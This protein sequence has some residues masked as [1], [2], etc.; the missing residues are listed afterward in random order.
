M[1]IFV[2][3]QSGGTSGTDALSVPRDVLVRRAL[4]MVGA[5]T[6]TDLPRPEQMTDAVMVLNLMIK[7]WSLEG[8]LWLRQFVSVSL[9]AGQNSY[10]LG[11]DGTPV[12]DRPVHIYS[13]NRMS[14]SGNEIPMVP[15]TRTD[16]MAVPNKTSVGTPVQYY[17]DPQTVNGTLY[18]WPTPPTN[19]S[20]VLKLDA[21]R[22]L[23]TMLDNL[24]SFDLPPQWYDAITYCLAAR[25]APEY[26][27]PLGERQLLEAE[28]NALFNKA[29]IDDRDMAS[30]YFGVRA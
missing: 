23:D 10:T 13:C 12:I 21:D 19:T 11:P 15:L 22:Q 5:Y 16:W 29:S 8:F 4:R 24:N 2:D 1:P 25:L 27:L 6:S 18:V 20:D 9:V 14:S 28:A 26:G 30:V 17:Y 7:A 3:P